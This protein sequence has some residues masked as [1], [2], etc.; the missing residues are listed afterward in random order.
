[1][2]NMPK[3]RKRSA[4]VRMEEVVAAREAAKEVQVKVCN[5]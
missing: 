1:V 2:I 5:T 3:G 4:C